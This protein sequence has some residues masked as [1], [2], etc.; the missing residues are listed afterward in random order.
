MA[1]YNIKTS[2]IIFKIN[3]SATFKI[4]KSRKYIPKTESPEA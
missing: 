2:Q 1:D 4:I 3:T